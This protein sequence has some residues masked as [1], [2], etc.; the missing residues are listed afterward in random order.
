MDK[1]NEFAQEYLPLFQ[2]FQVKLQEKAQ[3][4]FNPSPTL[5][6]TASLSITSSST[7]TTTT[8]STPED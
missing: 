8:N 6:S 1:I 4:L 5:P 2:K 3:G 7:S